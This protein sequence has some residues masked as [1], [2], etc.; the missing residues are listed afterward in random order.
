MVIE[1]MKK[2]KNGEDLTLE[3]LAPNINF[4]IGV[5]ICSKKNQCYHSIYF[6]YLMLLENNNI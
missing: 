5:I 2:V 4:K 3:K 1:E 6:C